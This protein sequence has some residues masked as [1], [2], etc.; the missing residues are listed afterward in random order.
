MK[1][2]LLIAG[3]L[4]SF[5]VNATVVKSANKQSHSMPSHDVSV[6][7]ARSHTSTINS[8]SSKT[9]KGA[10]PSGASEPDTILTGGNVVSSADINATPA[11]IKPGMSVSTVTV[12][13]IES[14]TN[15]VRNWCSYREDDVEYM[16]DEERGYFGFVIQK[17]LLSENVQ[18]FIDG[19]YPSNQGLIDRVGEHKVIGT[20]CIV[21][22]SKD[23]IMQ[24]LIEPFEVDKRGV[25]YGDFQNGLH[26]LFYYGDSE[27]SRF[28]TGVR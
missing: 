9:I 24:K 20:A 12:E 5:A 26:A 15:D 21:E 8:S 14:D 6:I 28:V 27:F 22:R 25:Q 3:L 2:Q 17:G 1:S 23:M 10:K 16:A 11:L 18:R 13:T 19:F 4:C 7:K